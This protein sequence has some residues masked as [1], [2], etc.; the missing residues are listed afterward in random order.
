[1]SFSLH[2]KG[3]IY[4]LIDVA[5]LESAAKGLNMHIDY[6]KLRKIFLP[7]HLKQLR[8]Y[9][10]RHDSTNQINF[11]A[12][13]RHR[14]YTLITKPLKIIKDPT[15]DKGYLRK[16]NFD[17]EISVDALSFLT[18]Y[19]TLV[20]FSGD[21][22]FHYLVKKLR[23]CGKIVIVIS[24][25]NHISRE[26]IESSNRYIDLKSLRNTIE[27]INTQKSPSLGP[28]PSTGS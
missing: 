18:D 25:K 8:F 21:S 11:F 13:L 27:R 12:F 1:M 19:E 4:A 6:R 10:V 15:R 20:L 17:V 16:A 24:A 28:S 23:Q 7:D 5:N 14:G 2:T 9:S 26:L 3:A 22:D